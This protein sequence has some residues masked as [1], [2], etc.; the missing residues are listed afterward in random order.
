VIRVVN[1]Y[2]SCFGIR[3]FVGI[4][5]GGMYVSCI[6]ILVVDWNMGCAY[7]CIVCVLEYEWWV[8]TYRVLAYGLLVG[9]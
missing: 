2:V 6:V 4:R 9:I 5:V 1:I 3:V 7:L 8:V